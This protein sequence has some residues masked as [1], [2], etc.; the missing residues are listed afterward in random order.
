MDSTFDVTGIL[1][2]PSKL[3]TLAVGLQSSLII[4]STDLCMRIEFYK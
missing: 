2:I 3:E 1:T 4:A